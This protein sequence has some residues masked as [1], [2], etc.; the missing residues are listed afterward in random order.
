MHTAKLISITK[1]LVEGLVTAEDLISYC[2][3]VSAPDN[4]LKIE[5][6]PRLLKYCIEHEHWS[7]FE[8]VSMSVEIRTSRS[9]A[10]Q[11]LRHKSF[12]FQEFSQRY[13]QV[14]DRPEKAKGRK[15]AV[16]NRQSS[17]DELD[18]MQQGHWDVL[19]TIAYD[20]CYT[21]YTK[22]LELGVAR[23]QA[24]DLLPLATPTTLYM[25]GTCRSF[26]HYLSLRTQPDTQLEHRTVAEAIKSIFI[27]QFPHVSEALEW[28]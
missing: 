9:I 21:A 15:Q 18:E 28:K 22:A 11:I 3:R 20:A 17:V 5:T 6:A 2:A 23:E 27:Q 14:A 1:P 7:I 12:S 16:K 10:A 13:S 4:Q 25:S 26:I 19:Q 24:R 8:Q